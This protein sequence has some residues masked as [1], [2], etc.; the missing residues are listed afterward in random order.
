MNQKRVG[1]ILREAREEKKLTV[2][3]VSKDTNISVK[4]ILALETE[5]Y[6]QFPG[7]TFTIGFLKNYGS[8]LK[9]DTGMLVNLYRGEKIEESQ[10]P[11][12]ELTRPTSSFYYDFNI[13][14]NKIITA[15]SALMLVIAGFLLFTFVFDGSSGD[16]EVSEDGRRKLEIP[17][18]IDFV[19]RSVP[20]TRPESFILT[21]NQGVSFSV[22]NQQ[23]KLFITGVEQGNDSNTALLGFNVYPELSVHKF[24]LA[25]GQEKVLSYSI[26]EI[27]SLRRSIRITAQSVTGSS[28]KVLVSLNEEERP[29]NGT[30]QKTGA[31]DS[32]STKTLGDVPIQVTLFFSKPSYAEFII[33]GQMGFRGLVQN[34]ETRS[35]EAKDRLELKV[36]DG[37]AVEM[38]Q[39]GKTKVVLGR[40]GKLVKKV[41]VKTPNPY[42]ST[43]FIIKELG[44]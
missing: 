35:L 20:E 24:K 29:G 42:D 33:D 1:Q 18:N 43:Q 10:A 8:Y 15:V 6:A 44:E 36:G 28:A 16:D 27:S 23:C 17:E 32:N 30:S 11:L 3:D 41:F 2:K 4:Y 19:N 22:S 13:D 12:E 34:G 25:E 40:P 38:I 39:N 31:E 9:L 26:P 7:E 21:T 14:K 37:S 5:D